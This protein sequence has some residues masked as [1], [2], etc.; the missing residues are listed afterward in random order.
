MARDIRLVAHKKSLPFVRNAL[1]FIE[2]QA[3]ELVG[4]AASIQELEQI[5]QMQSDV[6]S[7]VIVVG[8]PFG[9][10]QRLPG[11]RYLFLNLSVVSFAGAPWDYSLSGARVIAAKRRA[12]I[13]KMAS[14]DMLLDYLPHQAASLARKLRRNV[15]ALPIAVDTIETFPPEFDVCFVGSRSPRRERVLSRLG[16]MG[17]QMSP[18][19]GVTLEDVTRRSRLTLNVHAHRS[20]H[21]ETPRIVGAISSGSVVATEPC[22]GMAEAFPREMYLEASIADLPATVASA[23]STGT[24]DEIANR[25]SDWYRSTYYPEAVA[26]WRS[27]L[28]G[29]L[30]SA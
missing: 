26:A 14:Y 10:P 3:V 24:Y 29:L 27:V 28:S 11:R 13:R 20:N 30:S 15:S 25:A 2:R 21:L 9:P 5:D 18:R 12:Y 22:Y 16:N 23:L 19:S 6:G 1:K 8:D 4:D 17:V 7:A